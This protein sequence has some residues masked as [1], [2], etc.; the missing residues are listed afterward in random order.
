MLVVK[1]LPCYFRSPSFEINLLILI[2]L[3]VQTVGP[4]SARLAPANIVEW[5]GDVCVSGIK[6]QHLLRQFIY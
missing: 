6:S 4:A 3:I 1:L 5:N 2:S